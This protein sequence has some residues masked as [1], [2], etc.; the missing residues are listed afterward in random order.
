MSTPAKVDTPSVTP[1]ANVPVGT[2]GPVGTPGSVIP[3]MAEPIWPLGT[4]L[5]MVLYTS[6]TPQANFVGLDQPLLVWDGLT[7]GNYADVRDSGIMVDI[8]SSVRNGNG[9]LWLD[10]FLLKGGGSNPLQKDRADVAVFRKR[11]YYRET[12]DD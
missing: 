2:S 10:V 1:L 7:Y 5:S 8:P 6:T 4:P 12:L 3:L 9:S 11:A